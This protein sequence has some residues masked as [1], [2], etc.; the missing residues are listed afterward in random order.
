MRRLASSERGSSREFLR[1]KRFNF[2]QHFLVNLEVSGDQIA[3]LK[4]I[5]S[6]AQISDHA[7]GLFD[8][9][10]TGGK[11]PLR[12]PQLPESIDSTGCQPGEIQC[13]RPWAA[14]PGGIFDQGLHHAEIRLYMALIAI[15]NACSQQSAMQILL[16][17]NPNAVIVE[18]RA[19]ASVGAEGLIPQRVIDHGRF[20]FATILQGDGDGELGESMEIIGGAVQGINDPQVIVSRVAAA[21][22]G[23]DGM[24]GI[25]F[26]NGIDNDLFRSAIYFGNKII[27]LFFL[28]LNLVHVIEVIE[29]QL[30]SFAGSAGGN[31]RYG[32]HGFA[33]NP[34]RGDNLPLYSTTMKSIRIVL[35]E[36]SH[37]GNIGA[38][39]RAMK[40]MCLDD[41][42]LVQPQQFPTEEAMARAS[43]ADDILHEASVH[44][45]LDEAVADCTLVVG[46]SARLRSVSWPQLNPRECAELVMQRTP[47]GKVALVFGRERTGLTNAELERCQ[48]LVN[49]PANPDYSSLN[50]GMAVQVI[51]YELMMQGQQAAEPEVRELAR[52]G[53]MQGLFNH[54]EQALEDIGFLDPRKSDKLMRR[55]KRLFYRAE[56]DLDE[57]KILRGILSAAQ[58]RKSARRD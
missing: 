35:V 17:G 11:V 10:R 22:F 27:R 23:Q 58:G 36:T 7:T 26:F 29:Q 46:A 25:G 20:Q 18:I 8:Q 39:A 55:L 56:P 3:G 33:D 14:Y 48:Y 13:G 54:L 57:I 31:G 38:V 4:V 16:F 24:I 15:G 34:S 52:A 50:L 41:L 32:V 28:H 12:Q 5:V 42:A 2:L 45:S 40:N 47:L 6:A 53:D 44:Q 19:A 1:Q 9:Q 51:S 30:A 37:G 49:I 43:G 21:F